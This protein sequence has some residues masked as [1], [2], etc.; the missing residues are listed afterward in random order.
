MKSI[1]IIAIVAMTLG[2]CSRHTYVVNNSNGDSQATTKAAIGFPS[3]S[4][5]QNSNS[6]R[7]K[8]PEIGGSTQ[9]IGYLPNA[10]AFRMSGNYANNVAITLTDDGQLLYFPDPTDITADS[11]PV[12]LGEGWWLNNQGLGPNSVFTHYTFAEYA[13]L[14]EVPSPEQLKLSVIPG[15]KVTDFME[16]PIKIGEANNN[17]EEVK[18]FVKGH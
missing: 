12:S 18:E 16:L 1:L 13:S 3:S 7:V 9:S 5:T 11:E 6:I 15:A 14:P 2:A 4:K 10:T 17:I 8:M